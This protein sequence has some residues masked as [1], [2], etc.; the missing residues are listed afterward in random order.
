MYKLYL[1]IVASI[2]VFL[3]ICIY[4]LNTKILYP[5]FVIDI[6]SEPAGRVL[7]YL[8]IYLLSFYNE[9]LT[10]LIFCAVILLHIDIIN[11]LGI[12]NIS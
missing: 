3:Y 11:Y 4:S 5:R 8:C 6:F 7:I 12:K 10:L 9:L 2:L 1:N